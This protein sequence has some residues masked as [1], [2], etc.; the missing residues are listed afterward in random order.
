MNKKSILLTGVLAL[1]FF[2]LK[3]DIDGAAHHGH[4]DITGATTGAVGRCATSSC[5]G[6]NSAL[7]IVQLQ[8]LDSSTLT[9]ITTYNANKTYLVKLT[10]DA[11]AVTTS[12]PGFG[13]MVSAVNASHR[14]AGTYTIPTVS[15]S[16]IHAF[17]C[18]A[19]TVVEHSVTMRADVTGT[20]KYSVQFYWTA[21]AAMSDS[22]SFY[23]LLNA[24]NGDG[25][26]PGDYPNAGPK[27]TIYEDRADSVLLGVSATSML[28]NDFNVFPTYSNANPTISYTLATPTMVSLAIYDISGRT[29]AQ[30]SDYEIQSGNHSFQPSITNQ[31]TYFVRLVAGNIATTRMFFKQ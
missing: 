30:I 10:G 18:G 12:L 16:S 17:A 25:G 27:V 1:L 13:F 2:A 9:P 26:K 3:S 6:S 28:V 19:T 21:P 4:G 14:L 24:V 15:A 31:G 8:V 11:T 7:N 20:N 23:S 29:V 22:V 5:H